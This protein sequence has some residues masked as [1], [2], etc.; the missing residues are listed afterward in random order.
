MILIKPNFSSFLLSAHLVM[1]SQINLNMYVYQMKILLI[2]TN[3][4]TTIHVLEPKGSYNSSISKTK[5]KHVMTLFCQTQ[6]C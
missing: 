2:A 1:Y 4:I 5:A 6:F 3:Q